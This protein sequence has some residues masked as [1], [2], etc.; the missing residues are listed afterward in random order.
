[1]LAPI[2]V[3]VPKWIS[4]TKVLVNLTEDVVFEVG[5]WK[6]RVRNDVEKSNDLILKVLQP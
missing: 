6:V 4:S 2:P 5:N 1:V 3:L